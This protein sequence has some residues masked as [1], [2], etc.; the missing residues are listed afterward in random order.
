MTQAA[1]QNLYFL[2]RRRTP[3]LAPTPYARGPCEDPELEQALL[4]CTEQVLTLIKARRFTAAQSHLERMVSRV[5][6]A[7]N[8]IPNLRLNLL[9]FARLLSLQGAVLTRLEQ[10]SGAAFAFAQARACLNRLMAKALL[11]GFGRTRQSLRISLGLV[12]LEQA[13]LTLRQRAYSQAIAQ[14]ARIL[15]RTVQNGE[16]QNVRWLQAHAHLVIGWAHYE[17]R[18]YQEARAQVRQALALAAT[19]EEAEPLNTLTQLRLLHAAGKDEEVLA[20]GVSGLQRL[21]S[22]AGIDCPPE[23]ARLAHL[24][25]LMRAISIAHRTLQVWAQVMPDEREEMGEFLVILGAQ[26]HAQGHPLQA[27]RLLLLAGALLPQADVIDI[28][29]FERVTRELGERALQEPRAFAVLRTLLRHPEVQQRWEFLEAVVEAVG[30]VTI[31][32]ALA[33]IAALKTHV[34][35]D[36]P[37]DTW[38]LIKEIQADLE[39]MLRIDGETARAIGMQVLSNTSVRFV[40]TTAVPLDKVRALLDLMEAV[41]RRWRLREAGMADPKPS[42]PE[43]EH[44]TDILEDGLVQRFT[45]PDAH[46]GSLTAKRN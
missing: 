32:P 24:R 6:H 46:P 43:T 9:S 41:I 15:K 20:V 10:F 35:G 3:A 34:A 18:Q 28:P 30:R 27:L 36:L 1:H 22:Q 16:A 33:S 8:T 19:L 42:T 17:Q 14:A 23:T 21:V 38:A 25:A 7:Q 5:R 12:D 40:V 13:Y 31:G 37:M 39:Q 11:Q 4:T 29:E 2:E 45:A 44:L 26:R